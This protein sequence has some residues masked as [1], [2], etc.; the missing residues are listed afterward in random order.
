M[1]RYQ[2]TIMSLKNEE[3]I[4]RQREKEAQKIIQENSLVYSMLLS[5][6]KSGDFEIKVLSI[7][8][9][10]IDAFKVL[11]YKV[12]KVKKRWYCP[13]RSPYVLIRWGDE[14]PDYI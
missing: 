11:G 12:K 14:T 7:D 10:T 2:A 3:E 1:N 6:I 4:Y 9:K 13:N 8:D 5:A